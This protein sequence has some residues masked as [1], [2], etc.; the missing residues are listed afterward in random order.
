MKQ[1][2]YQHGTI[3]RTNGKYKT[4]SLKDDTKKLSYSQRQPHN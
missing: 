3:L 4:F 1:S 2:V